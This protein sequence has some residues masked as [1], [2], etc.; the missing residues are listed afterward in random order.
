MFEPHI[1]SG[2]RLVC[3][4][5]GAG[6]LVGRLAPTVPPLANNFAVFE[7]IIVVVDIGPYAVDIAKLAAGGI[8]TRDDLADLAVDELTDATGM[9]EDDAK[10]LIMK[11]REHWF[12][13]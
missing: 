10:A 5:N 11:A 12:T 3:D 8:H 1:G 7:Q 9:E 4:R 6:L 2:Q 13:N